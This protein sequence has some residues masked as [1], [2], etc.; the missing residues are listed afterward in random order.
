VIGS[1]LRSRYE[2]TGLIT[3]GPI[4]A[5]YSARD[6]LTGRDVSVRIVKQPFCAEPTFV[7]ALSKAVAKYLVVHSSGV[8]VQA[9]MD[10]DDGLAFM[11]G[12]LTR[13]PSLADR[14]RKLAPFSVPVSV[15]TGI[16][17][18]QALDSIHRLGFVHGDLQS[19]NISVLADGE[20]KLQL[21]GIWEAYSASPTAGAIVVGSMAP[22]MAP[23]VSA[24]GMP[25]PRSDVY[26]V[27]ILLY[28]LLSGRRPYQAENPVATA[29][30]HTNLPTPS[31][32]SIN[33]STPVVLDEIVRKAMA[34]DPKDRYVSAGELLSD[35]R[36]LQDALRFG[37]A[38]S[39][40]LRGGANVSAKQVVP[41]PVA[42]K[43]AAIR[44]TEQT[45]EPKPERDIPVWALIIAV[46][47]LAVF[48]SLVGV[49]VVFNLSTPRLIKV[50]NIKGL[51]ATEARGVLETS[52]LHMK[53][54]YRQPSDQV[55]MD[56]VL[57]VDPE[58]NSKVKEGGL[59][60]VILSAGSRVVEVP[61]LTGDTLDGAKT[62]L[63]N[64][65]L[66]LDP[67]TGAAWDPSRA[68]KLVVKQIPAAQT[69]VGRSTLVKVFLNDP[70][71][72]P[73]EPAKPKTVTPATTTPGTAPPTPSTPDASAPDITT[74]TPPST[75]NKSNE[76]DIKVNL[77][78]ISQPTEIRLD[79]TDDN[80]TRTV[81][82]EMHKP[83]DQFVTST[84][85]VGKQVKFELYYDG[86][87]NSSW[88]Q[89]PEAKG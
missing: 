36:I 75:S 62:I 81:L 40:P 47:V 85:G 69:Q 26:A 46:F 64:L 52:H 9:E 50:P 65:N 44:D 21:T 74:S 57:D 31:V 32:R 38:L 2:L 4:F 71:A 66:N 84:T 8:E 54:A 80:G 63:G 83:G 22:Y 49:W 45:R 16:S 30:Q 61:D 42:P 78:N 14:I 58:P 35:L 23:E 86:Q 27:G 53:V 68:P 43:M 18:C 88:I 5:G 70:D 15:G 34:K 1:L 12:E 37:R 59:V 7:Q 60:M 10:E 72:P 11:V 19:G 28:E 33:P 89:K 76:Y 24:G 17:I 39:W 48:L 13:G 79:I 87:R 55:E 6:R 56:R 25:S 3:D 20:V 82:D 67:N 73:L 41:Q 77:N 51:S 29:L